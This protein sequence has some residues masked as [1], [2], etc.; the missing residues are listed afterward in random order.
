MTEPMIIDNVAVNGVS[1]QSVWIEG[2]KITRIGDRQAGGRSDMDG[3]GGALIAGLFD[4]HVHLLASAALLRSIDLSDLEEPLSIA[5]RLSAGCAA[6][7]P[8]DWIRAVGLDVDADSLP[9]LAA[10]DA[11]A[12]DNPLRIQHQSGGLWLLNSRALELAT[13]AAGPLPPGAERDEHGNATGRFWR[14]DRWLR[15]SIGADA[16]DLA[17]LGKQLARY[18]VCGVTDASATNDAASATMLAD[19]HRNGDLPQHLLVMS[20]DDLPYSRHYD[21]GPVKILLDDDRLPDL[22]GLAGVI[23]H[24]RARERNVAFHC[25]TAVQSAYALAVL[26][27]AGARAGDRLEHGSVI[28]PEMMPIIKAMGLLIVTQP[29]FL[30]TRGDRYL[31]RVEKMDATNLYRAASLSRHG[32]PLAASSDAP[33]GRLDPWEG[34]RAAV[35]RRTTEGRVI[36]P[37]DRVAPPSA[38]ALYQGGLDHPHVPRSVTVG[39]QADLCLLRCSLADAQEHLTADIVRATLIGGRIA[40]CS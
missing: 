30:S 31:D 40:Y 29:I 9:S 21:I 22:E 37:A 15:D 32:I 6:R 33:Y 14:E 24:A 18:G 3:S 12:A 10:L 11:I 1:G 26:Q 4:H 36:N 20:R 19:A 34:M 8:G 2:G 35:S 13:R 5:D 17:Q 27:E 39:A 28:T 38:L 23:R 16:P 7:R 25:A